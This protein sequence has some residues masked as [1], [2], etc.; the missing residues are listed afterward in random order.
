MRESVDHIW[1]DRILLVDHGDRLLSVC[2]KMS[3]VSDTWGPY[4]SATFKV[5]CTDFNHDYF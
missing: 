3:K 5:T 1:E 2:S 4:S